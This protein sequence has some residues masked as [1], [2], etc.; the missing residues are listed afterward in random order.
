MLNNDQ[1]NQLDEA[2]NDLKEALV[3]DLADSLKIVV[4]SRKSIHIE[5]TDY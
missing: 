5:N 2:M 4:N 3:K 1:L